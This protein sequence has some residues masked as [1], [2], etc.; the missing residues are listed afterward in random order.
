LP[1]RL[2]EASAA[3][4]RSLRSI[5]YPVGQLEVFVGANGVGKT[6]LYRA[7]ELLRAAAQNRLGIELAREGLRSALW[8]GRARRG[9]PVRLKLGAT[10]AGEGRGAPSY[11]YEVEVGL[12]A[13][14]SAAFETEP[15]VKLETLAAIMGERSVRLLDRKGAS[16]MARG[17]D[18]R[19]VEIDI[20][21]LESET[22]LARL[23]D[24]SRYPGLDLV[25]RT[26]LEWRF[27]HG[28]RTDPAS[29]LRR[30][31]VAVSSPTLASD[32]ANLAA[33][34][35]TL[36]E[37]RQ[38]TVELDEAVSSAFPGA[39]LIVPEPG[40]TAEF[41]MSFPEFPNRV[42]SA[43]E[44]SDG[45]LRFLALAG[46]LLGY[47]LPPFV[48]LN[49]PESSLHPDLLP[50]LAD[51]VVRASR[52][53]QVWLVTHSET[54]AEAVARAPGAARRRVLKADGATWIEGLRLFG[55]Y[56]EEEADES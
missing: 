25:R 18:G 42:F 23:Q 56:D 1:L 51:L 40:V 2:T 46:A 47:R 27:Y 11:R 36:S 9:Q 41:G 6:N 48:A 50:A 29:P 30:P 24:P 32:G 38:D 13:P 12:P 54:L 3:G 52:R 31:C 16:V 53:T 37:I 22:A 44:L 45:T 20:D 43:A 39:S 4:Y 15:Q 8:A 17:E 26:L 10:R 49:E 7:L 34:F 5:R 33:V 55:A 21:L 19:P 14:A 28:F 35:A